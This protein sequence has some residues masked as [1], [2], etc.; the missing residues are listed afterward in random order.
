MKRIALVFLTAAAACGGDEDPAPVATVI[1]FTPESLDPD[2]DAADDLTILVE[3]RDADGDLGEGL[4]EVH[5][6]RAD[7]L[8]AMFDLPA[9]ASDD[10]VDEGVAIEGELSIVVADVGDVAASSR[11]PVVCEDLGVAAV[12]AGEAIFCVV[13]TDAAGNAGPGDCTGPV[14]IGP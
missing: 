9:I 5:D 1:E 8:V 3:Y 2:D 6:C 7:D 14:A 11:P 12:A 10:A 13:L 4:A